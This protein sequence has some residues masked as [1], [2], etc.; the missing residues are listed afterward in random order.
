MATPNMDLVEII[1]G[2]TSGPQYATDIVANFSSIDSHD[3]TTGA[4]VK[5]PVAGMNINGDLPFAGNGAT[6]LGKS[7]YNSLGAALSGS[8]NYRSV[9]VVSGELYYLDGSGNAVAITSSGS[10]AGSAGNIT[11]LSSPASVTF[12]TNKYI[13]KDT[14]NSFAVMES[15]D[16]RLFEDSASAIT[17][18]VAL[19]SPSSLAATYSLSMPAA[20][21]ASTE[22]LA[23]SSG[24]A[25]GFVTANT[26]A[27]AVTRATGTTVAAGGVA[28][29]SSSGAA[30]TSST[31][32]V[33]VTN[34][35]VTITTSGRPVSLYLIPNT[36]GDSFIR[37]S[38]SGASDAEGEF[39]I[40]RDATTISTHTLAIEADDSPV[41]ALLRNAC[42]SS[43]ISMVDVVAAGTYTYKVQFRATSSARVILVNNSRLVAYEL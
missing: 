9:H 34:L 33:D 30:S 18:Y 5:I 10:V 28:I 32:L 23:S 22:Y 17:N 39:V 42:P 37:V 13:F 41:F 26:I 40:I 11:G 15:S 16:V 1:P 4:G 14:A 2:V 3:H 19:K 7:Q 29:S 6:G 38:A 36:S 12:S 21:P 43:A 31:S 25:L 20:L 8:G 24:G 27:A 35:T